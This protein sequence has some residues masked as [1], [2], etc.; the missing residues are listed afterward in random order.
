[1][2]SGTQGKIRAH[3]EEEGLSLSA[4]FNVAD[5]VGQIKPAS[6]R[7]DYDIV[8]NARISRRKKANYSNSTFNSAKTLIDWDSETDIPAKLPE[9]L[10]RVAAL[11]L[12]TKGQVTLLTGSTGFLR[13]AIVIDAFRPTPDLP[14]YAKARTYVGSLAV[15]TLGLLEAEA[16]ALSPEVDVIIHAGGEGSFLNLYESLCPQILGATKYLAGLALPRRV[17]IH[18][19]S[20]NR[21]IL[22][23][24]QT[25]SGEI[26]ASRSLLPLPDGSDGLT[27]AKT[28]KSIL[29]LEKVEDLIDYEPIGDIADSVF[30]HVM[31]SPQ[32][33]DE[34]K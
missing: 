26:L 5:Q 6:P 11:Q 34:G 25:T 23:T 30:L 24:G 33:S 31:T 9:S 27:A 10:E 14:E 16:E 28:L 12:R 22:F 13:G 1:M 8:S 4:E 32:P 21:V 7:D 15:P 17:P 3:D 2:T 19:V 29:A 18:F 20:T